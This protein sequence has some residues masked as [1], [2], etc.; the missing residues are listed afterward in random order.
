MEREQEEL[1]SSRSQPSGAPK[2]A[3]TEA[4]PSAVFTKTDFVVL[5][6]KADAVAE[7]AHLAYWISGETADYHQGEILREFDELA[8]LVTRFRQSR[9]A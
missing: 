1:G 9:A 2:S 3:A 4:A 7:S 6:M 8:T 5:K